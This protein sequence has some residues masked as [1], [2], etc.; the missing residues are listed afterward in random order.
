MR[1]VVREESTLVL[2][3]LDGSGSRKAITLRVSWKSAALDP[4]VDSRRKRVRTGAGRFVSWWLSE[5]PLNN[6][7]STPSSSAWLAPKWEKVKGF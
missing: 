6:S 1:D 5:I 2:C 3:C 4:M 7:R